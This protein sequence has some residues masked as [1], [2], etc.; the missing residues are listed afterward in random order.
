MADTFVTCLSVCKK[1]GGDGKEKRKLD[2]MGS[3][4]PSAGRGE[5]GFVT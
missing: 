3:A 1:E 2:E 4:T 5:L